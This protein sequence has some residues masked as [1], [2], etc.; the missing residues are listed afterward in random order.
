MWRNCSR[1]SCRP[2]AVFSRLRRL[3]TSRRQEAL[4]LSLHVFVDILRVQR[5][6][7]QRSE[8]RRP[9]PH[10]QACI[11]T[12]RHSCRSVLYISRKFC[13]EMF[14]TLESGLEGDTI[15]VLWRVDR[16]QAGELKHHYRSE[17]SWAPVI[18]LLMSLTSN[19]ARE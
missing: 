11:V 6:I 8:S 19:L 7:Q 17:F 18:M 5:Q 2:L 3:D 12:I 9:L 4:H 13:V 1:G 14:T 10:V 16:A 15:R